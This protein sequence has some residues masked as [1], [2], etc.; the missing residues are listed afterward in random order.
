V[1]LL[2]EFPWTSLLPP[3]DRDAFVDDITRTVVAAAALGWLDP[4]AQVV[5]EWRATA[6]IHAD[7]RQA[8]RLHRPIT[9]RGSSVRRPFK[10]TKGQASPTL[11]ANLRTADG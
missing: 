1:S 2:D 4:L 9:T 6:Q 11:L 7:P 3:A 10:L 8:R 5:D